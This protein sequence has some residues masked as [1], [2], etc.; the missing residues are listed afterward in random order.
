M[1]EKLYAFLDERGIKG[2]FFDYVLT[3]NPMQI[4]EDL[5][6]DV[7][8]D[9]DGRDCISCAFIWDKTSE[10]FDYWEELNN[11]WREFRV[12]N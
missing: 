12:Q 3:L 6:F 10:G 1:R 4:D 5:Y 7:M 9:P 11:E 8:I 2:L